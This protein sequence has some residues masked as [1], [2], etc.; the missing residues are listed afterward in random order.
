MSETTPHGKV[1]EDK[2]GSLYWKPA[3]F[4]GRVDPMEIV[5]Q[6]PTAQEFERWEA[7]SRE[8]GYAEGYA[9]GYDKGV[10]EATAEILAKYAELPDLLNAVSEPLLQVNEEVETELMRMV[11]AIAQQLVRRELKTQPGEIIGTIRACLQQL[12]SSAVNVSVHVHPEDAA[13]IR[14]LLSEAGSDAD[15]KL[16]EDPLIS[17]GGCMIHTDK[18]QIDATLESQLQR[19]AAGTLAKARLDD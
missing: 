3:A 5:R 17:R 14:N 8:Q 9:I 2:D 18:S 6:P 10:K 11:V 12:P 15:W 13:L 4:D 1:F 16:K 19:L 7:E